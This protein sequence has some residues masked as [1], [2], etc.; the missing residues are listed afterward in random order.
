MTLPV[1]WTPEANQDLL[2]ARTWYDKTETAD[3]QNVPQLFDEW[4]LV[5][6]ASVP[7]FRPPQCH[8]VCILPCV[9]GWA[10]ILLA[11]MGVAPARIHKPETGVINEH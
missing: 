10:R 11:E 5:S 6:V 4:K 7:S 2:D 3:R 9:L 1:F 8:R